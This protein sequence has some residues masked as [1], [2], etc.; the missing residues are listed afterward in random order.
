MINKGDFPPTV[1]EP[2]KNQREASVVK[3]TDLIRL[4]R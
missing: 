1:Q 4:D 3:S 2:R